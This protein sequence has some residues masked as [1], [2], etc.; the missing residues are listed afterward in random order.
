MH[1]PLGREVL[2]AHGDAVSPLEEEARVEAGGAE[3]AEV[4]RE[5]A[6]VADQE[7]LESKVPQL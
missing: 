6:P 4:V 2:H 1:D 3:A 7:V 5:L